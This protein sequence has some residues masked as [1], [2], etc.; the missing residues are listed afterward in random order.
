MKSTRAPRRV[1]TEL[2]RWLDLLRDRF[3]T[4][5]AIAERLGV[6][7]SGMLRGAKAGSLS[8]EN[9]LNLARLA[10]EHPSKVLRM[11]NK[12]DVADLIEQL[13]GPGREALTARQL[14]VLDLFEQVKGNQERCEALLFTMRTFADAAALHGL[15]ASLRRTDRASAPAHEPEP[16]A[17]THAKPPGR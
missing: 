14:E 9:L 3:G 13:Y 6:T 2:L 4:Y 7:E 1:Q 15:T 8:V 12:S 11:G 16:P 10:E 17:T 5:R